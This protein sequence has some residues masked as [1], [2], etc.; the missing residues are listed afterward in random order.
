MNEGWHERVASE[1][2]VTVTDVEAILARRRIHSRVGARTARKLR[3][4][5]ITFTG[6]KRGKATGN[7]N[8]SWLDLRD[9]VWAVAS[10]GTNLVGK[11]TVLEVMLWALR[12]EPKNLQDDVQK[13]LD[14]VRVEFM[15]DDHPHAVDFMVTKGVPSGS[16]LRERPDK[17]I[18]IVDSFETHQGFAAAM[19][20][21]MMEALDLD[22]IPYQ[23][24]KD[25]AAQI[26]H[27]GWKALCSGLYFWGDHEFLLGDT[28]WGGLPARI[29][30]LYVGLPWAST[31]MQAATAQKDLIAEEMRIRVIQ[32]AA[33]E[34]TG[35][36][37][38]QIE[39]DL[40]KARARL[41]DLSGEIDFAQH[42]E[43][44]AEAVVQ[45]AAACSELE[46]RL[47]KAENE[48]GVLK[49]AADAD[50]REARNI[51]ET[52]VATTFFNGLQPTCCPRCEAAVSK[53]RIKRE[54]TDL[55]CSVCAEPIPTEKV[56]DVNER[57]AEA[58]QRA[59]VTKDASDRANTIVRELK[60]DLKAERKKML[61]ARDDLG[62]SPTSSSLRERRE[63]ELEIASLEG[64]LK[65]HDESA[66]VPIESPDRAVVDA[67][68]AI[69]KQEMDAAAN[70]LL[71]DLGD[72][73]LQLAQRFGFVSLEWV[74]IDAQANMTLSKGGTISVF[75]KLTIGERLRLRIA[76]AI[77]LLRI[78]KRLGVG[79]HPGLLL[80]DSPGSQET[81]ETNLEAFL[82]ELRTI[83]DK[84]VGLQVFV[85]SAKGT[86]V[87]TLLEP[88]RCRVAAKGQYLW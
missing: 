84:E 1:A 24:G 68:H 33:V 14:H 35:K 40:K 44:L 85:S 49:E 18:E 31:V 55:S 19:S 41:A 75:G 86:E 67:A 34:R 72:E 30:Q 37:R 2:G 39:Q 23:Q 59:A 70:K 47:A 82:K 78:G 56:E 61:Q 74:K 4:T 42:V 25:E 46:R 32:R 63:V 65:A 20:R 12:G 62:A 6:E 21:F 52:F 50:E 10:D 3:V 79:R 88:E 54:Q 57:L 58:E 26:S 17:S 13:W 27:H 51:R 16:L 48:A 43:R 45:T 73:V 36:A 7:I 83:A 69:A 71:T 76:T 53:D 11:S 9:G 8:F 15:L 29:L 64:M 87:S 77:A 5:S 80:V 60:G 81:D 66:A 22:P 28:K 38:I